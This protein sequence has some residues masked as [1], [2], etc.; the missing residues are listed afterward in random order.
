MH[1]PHVLLLLAC[2]L[3]VPATAPAADEPFDLLAV[4]RQELDRSLDNLAESGEAPMYFLQY[5]VTDIHEYNL[6]VANGGL[7]APTE[8]D[9]R[10]LDVDLRVG[11]MELDNTHEIRGGSWRD[12]YSPT[13]LVDFAL[14]DD[15]D[16]VRA[17]LWNETEF[18]FMK[19]NERLTKVEANRQVKVEEEDL[20]NDFSPGRAAAAHRD[21]R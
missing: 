1:R 5:S 4:M 19:A 18:Q 14:D 11:S 20:S 10:Y 15:P 13:R 16:A 9:H 3:A 2:L 17:A 21:R 6:S 12:N 7:N 8:S